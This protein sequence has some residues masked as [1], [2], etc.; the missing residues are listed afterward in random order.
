LLA[1]LLRPILYVVFAF[2][3]S[4]Q[5]VFPSLPAGLWRIEHPDRGTD[6]KPCQEPS[7]TTAIAIRHKKIPPI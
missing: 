3:R 7:K 5:K 1:S 6:P 4:P 2:F